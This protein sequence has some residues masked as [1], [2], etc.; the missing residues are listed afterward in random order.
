MESHKSYIS[1]YD[2]KR[3]TIIKIQKQSQSVRFSSIPAP[4]KSCVVYP[5]CV[6]PRYAHVVSIELASIRIP[7][8]DPKEPYRLVKQLVLK[9]TRQVEL[10]TSPKQTDDKFSGTEV[11]AILLSDFIFRMVRYL[12]RWFNNTPGF[13]S[14]GVRSLLM[15]TVY[16][17]RI[18][19]RVGDFALTTYNVHRLFAVCMLL[20]AK[21]SEDYIIANSYWA[22][23]AG[24][25]MKEL[26]SIE[27]D[28]CNLCGF[29]LYISD[30]KLKELYETYTA[31]FLIDSMV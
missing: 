9:I 4:S 23:V 29:D 16:L 1:E 10:R 25:E 26:N 28:F 5:L 14:V 11:P 7:E 19:E 8:V 15:S 31:D 30:A 27:E 22:E 6:Q 2:V 18:K 13:G 24:I 21:F 20:A 12:D 17:E 3:F